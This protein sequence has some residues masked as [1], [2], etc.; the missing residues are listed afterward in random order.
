MVITHNTTVVLSA[1]SRLLR[2]LTEG[3]LG[4]GAGAG[5]NLAKYERAGTTSRPAE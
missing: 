5:G 1:D 2:L 3:E 4:E